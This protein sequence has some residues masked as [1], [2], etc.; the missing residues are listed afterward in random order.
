MEH[1]SA[2]LILRQDALAAGFTDDEIRRRYSR[3]EWRR[4]RPGAY[5]VEP[6]WLS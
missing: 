2:E 1:D 4:L 6:A 5:L 3:G